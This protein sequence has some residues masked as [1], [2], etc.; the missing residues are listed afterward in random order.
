MRG[1][2]LKNAGEASDS[3][4]ASIVVTI[5]N[6]GIWLGVLL[7]PTPPFIIAEGLI[8]LLHRCYLAI[9]QSRKL[10]YP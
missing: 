5:A 7:S 6:I 8:E 4:E 3:V 2:P 1:N 10:E 9:L